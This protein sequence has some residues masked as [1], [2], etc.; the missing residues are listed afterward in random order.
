MN[1]WAKFDRKFC[2]CHG[3]GWAEVDL[4]IWKRCA[5]HWHGQTAPA[6]ESVIANNIF[7][8]E[9]DDNIRQEIRVSKLMIEELTLQLKQEQEHLLELQTELQENIPTITWNRNK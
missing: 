8:Q 9:R 2:P 7:T 1:D 6:S 3:S 5:I 4:G